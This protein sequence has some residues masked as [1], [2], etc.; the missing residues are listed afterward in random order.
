MADPLGYQS[1]QP[2]PP[3]ETGVEFVMPQ[4]ALQRILAFIGRS[5]DDVVNEPIAKNQVLGYFKLSKQIERSGEVR[6]LEK[7][8]NEP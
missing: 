4:R 3:S 8:W 1:P 7:Q 5:I 6:E 2:L